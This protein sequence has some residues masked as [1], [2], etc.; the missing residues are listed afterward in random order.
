MAKMKTLIVY[1]SYT[2]NN[3]KVAKEL[4]NLIKADVV[5]LQDWLLQL[6]LAALYFIGGMMASL[7]IP[8]QINYIDKNIDLYERIILMGPV[9]GWKLVP[10]IKSFIKKYLK[11][12]SKFS[13]L[14]ICGGGKKYFE[15]IS[16]DF[17]KLTGE[18]PKKLLMLSERELK[19]AK[20]KDQLKTFV[21]E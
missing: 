15:Q 9:W 2:G 5:K 3:Q 14:I 21:K 8:T 6:P 12:K 1:Y 19:E 10:A 18:K 20:Y 4:S 16:N 7:S 17:M 13:L 11:Y